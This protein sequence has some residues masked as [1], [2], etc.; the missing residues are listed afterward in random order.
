MAALLNHVWTL[1]T[2]SKF[3]RRSTTFLNT[4]PEVQRCFHQLSAVQRNS[5]CLK[6]VRIQLSQ[7]EREKIQLSCV[8][9]IA[10]RY[11][12]TS[13]NQ[14]SNGKV[15]YLPEPPQVP[16]PQQL[17]EALNSLGEASL[18]S[19][20]L[21]GWYPPGLVQQC[22]D[23]IHCTFNLP[24]WTTII[25][26]T[27]ML[28]TVMFPVVVKAR[29]NAINLHNHMPTMTKLQ[30]RFT[31]AR[32]SADPM[33]AAKA[34]HELATFMQ[35]NNINPVKSFMIPMIQ[36]PVFL[37]MF[38][39]L[40]QMSTLPIEGFKD[41][42]IFWFTDLS[43]PDPVYC[44]PMLT[45]ATLAATIEMGADGIKANSMGHNIKWFMRALPIVMFPIIFNFPAAMLCYWFTSNTFSLVQV[46]FLKIPAVQTYFNLGTMVQ[47]PQSAIP[48]KAFVDGFKESWNNAKMAQALEQR[49]RL[50]DVRFKEAGQGPLQ[51][52][53]LYD[54]TKSKKKS[55]SP[56]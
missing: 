36:M 29:K 5:Y 10:V 6:D 20:G 25:V 38:F 12:S 55:I 50:D 7:R 17:V 13:S 4:R 45:V 15:D 37:S 26:F 27:V 8:S 47:H 32:S 49:Q 3:I 28:R 18:A 53:Y 52:T 39:A 35:R 9:L 16:E 33:E 51:K 11:D 19:Q 44:L 46:A 43:I 2:C 34:G 22:L 30:Q 54:P 24:W 21:G 31:D 42:G 48:K 40:R 23:V 1:K 14:V 41:G 56:P